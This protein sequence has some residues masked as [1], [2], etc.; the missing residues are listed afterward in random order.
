VIQA[1]TQGDVAAAVAAVPRET[2]AA[3]CALLSRLLAVDPG[4]RAGLGDVMRD[5]W[6]VQFLPDLS[7]LSCA[8]PSEAQ[9]EAEIRAMVQVRLFEL[10]VGAR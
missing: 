5:P 2:S 8:A 6:F 3:C 10:G 9:S 1:L 7:Q 4:V